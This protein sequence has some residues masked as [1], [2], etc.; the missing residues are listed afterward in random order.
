MNLVKLPKTFDATFQIILVDQKIFLWTNDNTQLTL[1]QDYYLGTNDYVQL[2]NGDYIRLKH[3]SCE[4]HFKSSISI[5]DI[6]NEYF[7]K[8]QTQSN[9]NIPRNT[10]MSSTPPR[11]S[12]PKPISPVLNRISSMPPK[13]ATTP[14]KS[15]TPVNSPKKPQ[16]PRTVI[17]KNSMSTTKQSTPKHP[18]D[19]FLEL[20]TSSVDS[21]STEVL[22]ELSDTDD[23]E[24]IIANLSD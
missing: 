1:N 20:S 18:V 8:I 17:N 13:M 16:T 4:F 3:W 19:D 6:P 15:K 7:S 5:P 10:K 21:P 11:P 12:V 24:E 14:V 22:C 9:E 2:R 23:S